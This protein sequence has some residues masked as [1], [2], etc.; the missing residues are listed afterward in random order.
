MNGLFIRDESL[1][2]TLVVVDWLI[3]RETFC[4]GRMSPLNISSGSFK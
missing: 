2:G 4:H 3:A 1:K